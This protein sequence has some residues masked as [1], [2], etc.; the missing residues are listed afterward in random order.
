MFRNDLFDDPAVL[1]LAT[2]LKL[3]VDSVIGKLCR[4]WSWVDRHCL[5]EKLDGLSVTAIDG[6]VKRKG[7]TDAM[8]KVG[9]ISGT[10]SGGYF[11]PNYDRW[12][13]KSAKK[14]ALTARR[15]AN[16]RERKKVTAVTLALTRVTPH[17]RGENIK[18]KTPLTPLARGEPVR[19]L[20]QEL[21][22]ND[23]EPV[24][25][26]N[27]RSLARACQVVSDAKLDASA[28]RIKFDA[29]KYHFD[30]AITLNAFIRSLSTLTPPLHNPLAE[31]MKR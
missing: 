19:V 9:W 4:F 25:K 27:Q 7:F 29:W 20:L 1:I 6:I 10:K 30:Y 15:V 31:H 26:S 16:Y 11:I 3:N 13:S 17:S 28:I 2:D 18:K 12:F 21:F 22:F 23:A 8:L 5:T 24:A 14:R